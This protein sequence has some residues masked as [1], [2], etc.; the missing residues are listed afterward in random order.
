[1]PR[2]TAEARRADVSF[3]SPLTSPL[4]C[5]PRLGRFQFFGEWAL[6]TASGASKGSGVH[7]ASVVSETEVELYV[8]SKCARRPP[9]QPASPTRPLPCPLAPSDRC[10]PV[11]AVV[12]LRQAMPLP[13]RPARVV[14][15]SDPSPLRNGHGARSVSRASAAV[16]TI[17]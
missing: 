12:G 8:L 3:L 5:P 7:S 16:G 4:P 9:R 11:C 13:S 10:S 6:V 15:P 17:S 2:R 1:M 14:S